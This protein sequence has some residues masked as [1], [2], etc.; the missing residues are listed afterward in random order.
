[1]TDFRAVPVPIE[2]LGDIVRLPGLGRRWIRLDE[3]VREGLEPLG[4]ESGHFPGMFKNNRLNGPDRHGWLSGPEPCDGCGRSFRE[5]SG[6]KS[7]ASKPQ[8]HAMAFLV[9][10]DCR[11]NKM[12]CWDCAGSRETMIRACGRPFEECVAADGVDVFALVAQ[13]VYEDRLA[14]TPGYETLACHRAPLRGKY[15][16]RIDGRLR[17]LEE[18][19]SRSNR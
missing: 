18:K 16:K 13:I 8:E 7:P 3:F 19:L 1:M 17:S 12:F 15:A 11:E 2:K 5:L 9:S 14:D 10:P 4:S 6:G